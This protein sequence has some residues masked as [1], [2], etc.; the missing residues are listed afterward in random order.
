MKSSVPLPMGL[1]SDAIAPLPSSSIC[2]TAPT[3]NFA[4]GVEPRSSAAS[5]ESAG[6]WCWRLVPRLGEDVVQDQEAEAERPARDRALR[7]ETRAEPAAEGKLVDRRIE[8][9]TLALLVVLV[10]AEV[11]EALEADEAEAVADGDDAGRADGEAVRRAARPLA[12]VDGVVLRVRRDGE[13]EVEARVDPAIILAAGE[14]LERDALGAAIAVVDRQRRRAGRAR[15][16][17][18]RSR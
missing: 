16:P 5:H 6:R 7:E 10:V 12:H 1:P 8:A 2:A 4:P 11:A 3:L 17:A 13:R 15:S 9:L 18:R 14:A